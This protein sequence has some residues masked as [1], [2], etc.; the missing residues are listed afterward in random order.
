M[1]PP[2]Y[3]ALA[4]AG[5]APCIHPS[6]SQPL[7]HAR[8]PRPN[9]FYKFASTLCLSIYMAFVFFNTANVYHL[10]NRLD[11]FCFLYSTEASEPLV[12]K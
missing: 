3:G 2:P 1:S 6:G 11:R 4:G 5:E 9:L 7:P 8:G 12:A 10:P